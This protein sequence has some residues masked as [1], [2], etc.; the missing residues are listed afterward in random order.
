MITILAGLAAIQTL[1][2]Q[3]SFDLQA[4]QQFLESHQNMSTSQLLEMHPAGMFEREAR[5][6]WNTALYHDSIEIKYNLT[7]DEKSLLNKHGF[8]VTERLPEINPNDGRYDTFLDHFLDIWYKD[9]PVFISTDAILHA[10]H[11]NYDKLMMNIERGYLIERISKLLSDMHSKIPDLALNYTADSEMERM[12]RDVDIYLTVPLRLLG[13]EI[14][15]H[16]IENSVEIEQILALIAAEQFNVY[17]FFSENCKEIDFSQFRPRG[18]YTEDDN[19]M[20]YFRAMMWLGRIEIYLLPPKAETLTC[21]K[22]T[23]AD[24]QR[25]VID[26]FL[27]T[28]LMEAA[29]VHSVYDEIEQV[30]T[31]LVGEQDNVTPQN[32]SSLFE[33]LQITD[34]V[35]LLDTLLVQQFQDTLKTKSWAFQRIQSQILAHDPLSEEPV[36]P[37]AAFMLFG[38]RYIIDSYVTANVVYDKII[39]QDDFICRLF[40]ST[41]DI[42]FALGNDAAAQL[43]QPQLDEYH[44]A[45]NLTALRYLVD[46]YDDN[47]WQSSIYNMWLPWWQQKMNTQLASWTELRHDNLLYAKP[48][49]TSGF[50]CSYPCGYV[51][52][53]PQFFQ[54]MRTMGQVAAE[55]MAAIPFSDQTLQTNIVDYFNLVEGISDTLAAITQKELAGIALDAAPTSAVSG[56]LW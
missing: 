55:K 11:F 30:I 37:A 34:A 35:Q 44:Y 41:L 50:A 26:T 31:F 45:T 22:Q 25:Q 5:V 9:L 21:P 2:A 17:P 15:P 18:H 3:T 42:L 51:E 7:E 39:Y 53:M 24:I 12:L 8:V 49:Y 23:T 36:R 47:F 16:Y 46:S 19:L 56:T 38:Q 6:A 13:V 29:A 48:S 28:E 54:S 43:L 10:F 4:Y 1:S 33:M 14:A 27:L 52:P 32:V 20:R 40:P